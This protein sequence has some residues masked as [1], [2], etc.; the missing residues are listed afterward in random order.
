MMLL[1]QRLE[2]P[3]PAPRNLLP[4][5]LPDIIPG[6]VPAESVATAF[7]RD[8]KGNLFTQALTG[9]EPSKTNPFPGFADVLRNIQDAQL[10]LLA[11]DGEPTP[12][13]A[14]LEAPVT[15]GPRV[16]A[17]EERERSV[18]RAPQAKKHKSKKTDVE[19]GIV[20]AGI[21]FWHKKFAIEKPGG[22]G[23]T[24]R[25]ASFGG[26]KLNN[27]KCVN[28]PLNDQAS[29]DAFIGRNDFQNQEQLSNQFPESVWRARRV[30][31]IHLKVWRMERQ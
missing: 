1:F 3:D 12:V 17:G 5:G 2:M 19:L 15:L 16:F 29:I 18:L 6:L 10:D 31:F 21:T 24:S 23:L 22:G 30:R 14:D 9:L 4:A 13:V 11:D 25:F 28:E 20:D 27:G 26:L 8:T 7:F